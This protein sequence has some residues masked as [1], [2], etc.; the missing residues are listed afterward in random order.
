MSD[1]LILGITLPV[2]TAISAW[3]TIWLNGRNALKL[4]TQ[5]A[6]NNQIIAEASLKIVEA[7]E[8]MDV[9]EKKLDENH[10][11]VNGHM[12]KLLETTS[13]L[14]TATE[15]AKNEAEKK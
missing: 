11:L 2:I 8:K 13:A 5:I 10:V 3:V 12:T 9:V 7:K 6:K 15:K 14:A 1:T 4:A